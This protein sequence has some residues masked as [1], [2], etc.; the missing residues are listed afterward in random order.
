[1]RQAVAATRR[2]ALIFRYLGNHYHSLRYCVTDIVT[3][4]LFDVGSEYFEIN[5]K[6]MIT[7]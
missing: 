7:L 1:M 4:C 5:F 3:I 2:L 6:T